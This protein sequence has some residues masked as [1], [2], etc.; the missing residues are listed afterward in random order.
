MTNDLR[1]SEITLTPT[2]CLRGDSSTRVTGRASIGFALAIALI[3]LFAATK[4]IVADTLDPDLFWH[5]KVAE[6]LQ[7]DGVGPIVDHLSFNSQR[8]P[9]TPYSWLAELG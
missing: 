3:A 7:H 6:Q 9:W 1:N 2:L 8:E 4:V 5:L